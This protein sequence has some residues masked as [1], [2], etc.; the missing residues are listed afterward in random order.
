MNVMLPEAGTVE[1]SIGQPVFSMPFMRSRAWTSCL[2][3]LVVPIAPATNSV[4]LEASMTP[5]LSM[6]IG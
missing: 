1:T 4:P 2:W 6:P 3:M 5:V